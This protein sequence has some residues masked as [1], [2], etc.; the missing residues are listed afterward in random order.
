MVDAVWIGSHIQQGTN[1]ASAAFMYR[2]HEWRPFA[3]TQSE[4]CLEGIELLDQGVE[5]LSIAR[6]LR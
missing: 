4:R 5:S 2:E 6:T 3:T 1:H